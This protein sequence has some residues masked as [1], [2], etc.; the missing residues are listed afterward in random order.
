[1]PL[2]GR[3]QMMIDK[4]MVMA[5]LWALAKAKRDA[6]EARPERVSTSWSFRIKGLNAGVKV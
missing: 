4:R 3:A 6:V 2:D 5:V 1:M